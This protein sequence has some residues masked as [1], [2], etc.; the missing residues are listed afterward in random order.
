MGFFETSDSLFNPNLRHLEDI[1]EKLV[2][3]GNNSQPP[4]LLF[5]FE[6]TE[7]DDAKRS[8][9]ADAFIDG[10]NRN[11]IIQIFTLLRNLNNPN[12]TAQVTR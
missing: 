9:R 7:S 12:I 2:N 1:T 5:E 4:R 10:P 11:K 6:F 3:T 8:I